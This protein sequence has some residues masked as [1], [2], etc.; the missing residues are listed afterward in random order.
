MLTHLRSGGR[1]KYIRLACV[2]RASRGEVNVKFF[3]E[4]K[5]REEEEGDGER[6]VCIAYTTGIRISYAPPGWFDVSL[7]LS[8]QK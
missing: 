1:R 8:N 4:E 7:G 6:D 3:F 5:G 2:Q